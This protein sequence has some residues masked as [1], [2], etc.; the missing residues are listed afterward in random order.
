[1]AAVQL[2][3]SQME[4][5]Q[6]TLTVHAACYEPGTILGTGEIVNKAEPLL[7]WSLLWK[8]WDIDCK[9]NTDQMMISTMKTDE[10]E[11]EGVL[12]ESRGALS[13]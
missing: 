2:L 10:W 11:L 13:T 6:V 8:E 3:R 5:A 12:P 9:W 1:M 4:S 7:S